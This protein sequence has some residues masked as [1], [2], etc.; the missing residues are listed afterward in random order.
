MVFASPGIQESTK[1]REEIAPGKHM[2]KKCENLGAESQTHE[3]GSY[4]SGAKAL[5][6]SL[7]SD[8]D[9]FWLHFSPQ[10]ASRP[11]LGAKMMRKWT[12]GE[13]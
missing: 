1:N 5:E 13:P 4:F 2:P 3:N 9:P 7:F 6:N 8:L 10:V 12:P 11:H